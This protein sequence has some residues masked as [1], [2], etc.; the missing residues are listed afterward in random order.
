M[1]LCCDSL[2]TPMGVLQ[3]SATDLGLTSI[4]FPDANLR[5]CKPKRSHPILEQS[6]QELS[7]YFRGDLTHFSIPLAWEGTYFQEAVWRALVA[8][9]F[10]HTV[11]YA[12]IAVAVGR[13][14]AARPV[15]GAVGRNPIPIIV[16][17]H[18]VI[19]SDR[20]LTGF[21][22]GLTIKET[23]LQLEGCVVSD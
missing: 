23:L 16:P 9:P 11:S 12:D 19:G 6:K 10:G 2:A 13:P 17:C 7:A 4:R 18:R 1:T 21:T 20:S 5:Q 22:G 15:G 3:L 8:I 14:R